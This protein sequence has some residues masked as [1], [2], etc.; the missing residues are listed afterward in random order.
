MSRVSSIFDSPMAKVL[1]TRTHKLSCDVVPP[2]GSANPERHDNVEHELNPRPEKLSLARTRPTGP[3]ASCGWAPLCMAIR[4]IDM[5]G[6]TEGSRGVGL[7]GHV[8][9][10]FDRHAQEREWAACERSKEV[11]I[12]GKIVEMGHV[13]VV[14]AGA[15]V[16]AGSR[17]TAGAST[18]AL[19]AGSSAA[20]LTAGSRAAALPL[21][22]AGA[23][24]HDG[25]RTRCSRSRRPHRRTEH[26]GPGEGRHSGRRD[27]VAV[28]SRGRDGG[29]GSREHN[30][31]LEDQCRRN[32]RQ[33][34]DMHDRAGRQTSSSAG[35]PTRNSCARDG[36]LLPP[37]AWAALPS[38]ARDLLKKRRQS[39]APTQTPS[40][41][42]KG[43]ADERLTD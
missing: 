42:E 10:I 30:E 40:S 5:P 32:K 31:S 24:D 20:T 2:D 33:G 34:C 3:A 28:G 29:R 39:K 12:L 41:V 4:P 21:N 23:H 6:N 43:V 13:L 19:T 16:P 8:L 27:P 7:S 17:A 15:S 35:V 9:T 1:S 37:E 25:G 22:D 38:S 18:A 36:R 26:R 11:D 14:Q